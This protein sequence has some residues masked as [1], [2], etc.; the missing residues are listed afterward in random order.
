ML[1]SPCDRQDSQRKWRKHG[2][3]GTI[4]EDAKKMYTYFEKGKNCIE[5]AIHNSSNDN[6]ASTI[7]FD[8]PACRMVTLAFILLAPSFERTF[9]YTL[10]P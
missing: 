3:I 6:R 9:Y 5:I 1:A 7:F 8:C 2:F 4:S 10:L